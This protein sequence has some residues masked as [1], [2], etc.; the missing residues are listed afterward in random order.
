MAL[1]GCRVVDPIL[2]DWRYTDGGGD[3]RITGSA[4]A[5][6]TATA[7]TPNTVNGTACVHRPAGAQFAI[8]GGDGAYTSEY[9][10]WT[11]P[12]C[13]Q[14]D[15]DPAATLK[16]FPFNRDK[17]DFCGRTPRNWGCDTLTRIRR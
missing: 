13:V 17:I 2:G 1:P 8:R 6:F 16:I 15:V 14:V 7:L 10:W 5:G 11:L 4:Q 9:S 12:E 3:L